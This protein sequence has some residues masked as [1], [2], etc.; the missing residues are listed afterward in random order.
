[1]LSKIKEDYL[2]DNLRAYMLSEVKAEGQAQSGGAADPVPIWDCR[3][4][5][6]RTEHEKGWGTPVCCL[7]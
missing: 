2:V 5:A 1:V 6:F 4:H 7:S 3:A